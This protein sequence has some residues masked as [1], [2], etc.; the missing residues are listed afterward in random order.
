[1]PPVPP[2]LREDMRDSPSKVPR[3]LRNS[4]LSGEDADVRRDSPGQAVEPIVLITVGEGSVVRAVCCGLAYLLTLPI[5][6]YWIIPVQYTFLD[7]VSEQLLFCTPRPSCSPSLVIS[8]NI[9]PSH[10]FYFLPTN[11]IVTFV[12]PADNSSV[13]IVSLPPPREPLDHLKLM[14]PC[15]LSLPLLNCHPCCARLYL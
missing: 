6:S 10:Q 15:S 3:L 7:R 11:F 13:I 14:L 8:L 4:Y 1:M 9:D 12:I 5:G 2:M